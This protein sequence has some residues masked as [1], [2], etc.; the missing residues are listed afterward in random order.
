MSFS[1]ILFTVW[2]SFFS[3]VLGRELRQLADCTT[4]F[5]IHPTGNGFGQRL[6]ATFLD[7]L[8]SFVDF[9][10]LSLIHPEG[11]MSNLSTS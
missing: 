2:L 10:R 6:P 11:G 1:R 4:S 3:F 8:D 5:I 9:Q 7:W